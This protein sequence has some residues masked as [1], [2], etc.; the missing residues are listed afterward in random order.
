M[1]QLFSRHKLCD[2][3]TGVIIHVTFAKLHLQACSSLSSFVEPPATSPFWLWHLSAIY[4][5]FKLSLPEFLNGLLISTQKSLNADTGVFS[6]ICIFLP[7]HSVNRNK[8]QRMT[9]S[10]RKAFCSTSTS[11]HSSLSWSIECECVCVCVY[12]FVW[13]VY[14]GVCVCACACG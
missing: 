14:I 6:L 10:L 7:P 9:L 3:Y 12:L 8:L 1:S 5:F 2:S 11:C 13:I 4:F